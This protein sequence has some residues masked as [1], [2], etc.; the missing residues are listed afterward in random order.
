MQFND[1]GLKGNASFS[2]LYHIFGGVEIE[3]NS[4]VD[5]L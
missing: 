2:V 3:L 1:N 5:G 4:D